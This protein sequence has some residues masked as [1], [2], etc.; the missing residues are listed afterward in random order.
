MTLDDASLRPVRRALF[1]LT[2]VVALVALAAMGTPVAPVDRS[3]SPQSGQTS[4]AR[5]ST[6]TVKQACRLSPRILT[7][8]WR[9]FDRVH[10]TDI[11]VV[12]K[13]PNFWGDFGRV[14][15]TGPWDY[16]QQVPLVLYGPG[17][18]VASGE[19][20]G[21]H[22]NITDVYPTVGRLL[23]VDLPPRE[24]EVLE[25]ALVPDAVGIP[26]LIMVVVWDGVGRNVLDRW[27][28][29]WPNLARLEAQG[30]SFLNASVGSSP[31]VTPSTHSSLGTGAFP[32]EHKVIA[33]NYRD[34]D[35]KIRSAFAR[36]DP[37]QLKLT[38]FADE[39]DRRLANKPKVGLLAWSVSG[40]PSTGPGAWITN[41]LGMLGHGTATRG[42]DRDQEALLG[43]SANITA[44]PRF[45]SLPRHLTH[46]STLEKRATEL[47]RADGRA[48]GKWL[49]HDI[50]DA[51]NN[52]AWVSFQTDVLE[53]MLGRGGY[54]QD[55]VPDIFLTNFK[56]SDTVAHPYTVDSK[57]TATVL[58]ATDK[59]LG[60]LVDYL[61]ENV[62]DYV[63]IVTADHGHTRNPRR[64]GAWPISP[65]QVAFD[66]N[67]HFGIPRGTSLVKNM[68]AVGIFLDYKVA[69]RYGVKARQ[70]AKFLSG[71]T[72]RANWREEDL[73]AGYEDRGHERV[74][75]AAFTKKQFPA[76]MKC[77]FGSG[78][79]PPDID[80]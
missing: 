53:R 56:P 54:G 13:A 31:S 17:R 52:P 29:R 60:D 63:V 7:R 20:L 48:D 40:S 57:E 55:A 67:A 59:A 68:E 12:P 77:A 43:D 72:I 44:S 69:R 11:T 61:D 32:R 22:V 50:L 35:G 28:G 10:S 37:R 25:S 24:G 74:L 49:G 58:E 62:G 23:G 79:P 16:L 3:S 39:I 2:S 19:R 34:R 5:S 1:L 42:G 71:Y 73:P 6:N 14:S 80:A 75:A 15:H 76:I 65:S 8:I 27:P 30:T 47:D 64:L 45:F 38:T 26:K 78:R 4:E 66:L 70:V 36:S 33:I 21:Q 18:I 41:H 9:G 51:H 46:F